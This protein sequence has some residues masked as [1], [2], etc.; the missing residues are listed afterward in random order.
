MYM[1]NLPLPRAV[2][3]TG[4]ATPQIAGDCDAGVMVDLAHGLDCKVYEAELTLESPTRVS[5]KRCTHGWAADKQVYFVIEFSQPAASVQVQGGWQDKLAASIGDKLAGKEIKAIFDRRRAPS[6]SYSRG[7]PAPASRAPQK[8]WPPKFRIGTSTRWSAKVNKPGVMH[9]PSWM[10]TSR[11]SHSR[12]TLLYR[13]VSRPRRP[14][15]HS[16]TWTAPIGARIIRIIR[17][18]AS[19][20]TRRSPY[21]TSIAANFHSS[22]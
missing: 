1:P 18:P 6:H 9:C 10:P 5:G 2:A 20:S 15:R 4:I 12:Q 17:I 3:C 21:G 11:T 14:G 8:T 19:P 22:C 16:T 7:F 13:R